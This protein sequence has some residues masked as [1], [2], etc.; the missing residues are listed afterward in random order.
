MCPLGYNNGISENPDA[1]E[2]HT[3]VIICNEVDIMPIQ[4]NR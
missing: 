4:F 3:E 2:T 1:E